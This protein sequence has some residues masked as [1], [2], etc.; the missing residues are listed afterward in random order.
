M[1][2]NGDGNIACHGE[3]I[4]T[5][6]NMYSKESIS[7]T[8]KPYG[9]GLFSKADEPANK[10]HNKYKVNHIAA[11]KHRKVSN[12]DHDDFDSDKIDNNDKDYESEGSVTTSTSGGTAINGRSGGGSS[13]ISRTPSPQL[14]IRNA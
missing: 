1:S 7:S 4:I 10:C 14:D 9:T 12:S 5:S 13:A 11:A 8:I 2:F 3:G 6:N